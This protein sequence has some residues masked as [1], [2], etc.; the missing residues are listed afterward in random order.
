MLKRCWQKF[1]GGLEKFFKKLIIFKKLKQETWTTIIL[2]LI[3]LIALCFSIDQG[4]ETRQYYRLSTV[5][6][7]QFYAQL[8]TTE[9]D[10]GVYVDNVGLGPASIKSIIIGINGKYYDIS[11][12]NEVVDAAHALGLK[13]YPFRV[14]TFFK[15]T[16]IKAN[17][18]CHII[19]VPVKA[20]KNGKALEKIRDAFSKAEIIVKYESIYG[21]K[22]TASQTSQDQK[23]AFYKLSH[24]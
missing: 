19:I 3:A 24:P 11:S 1:R 7:I 2:A 23:K 16:Y 6:Q 13:G 22:F 17:E 9:K 20:I 21:V 14:R 8:S 12:L 4:C 15:G 10:V 18:R 5:P